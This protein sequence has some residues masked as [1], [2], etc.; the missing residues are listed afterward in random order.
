MSALLEKLVWLYSK[1][2]IRHPQLKPVTLAHWL[3]ASSK[4]TSRLAESHYNFAALEWR[5]EMNGF[6]TR[7]A[8]T[9][10]GVEG[11]YCH[12]ASLE[13][14]ITGYWRFLDRAPYTGWE[15]HTRTGE[16][17]FNFIGPT[18][19]GS[20]G[21]ADGV[22]ALMPEADQLLRDATGRPGP[23]TPPEPRPASKSGTIVL[24]PGHGGTTRVRGSS[25]NNAIS[26]S[27]VKEKKMALEISLLI[28]EQLHELGPGNDFNLGVHLTRTE[29][30]NVGIQD[31]AQLAAEK[32]ADLFFCLHFNGNDPRATRKTRGTETFFRAAENGN[33]NP[34]ADEAF[35]RR[36]HD[37]MFAAI[38]RHDSRAVDRHV[39]PDTLSGPKSLGVLR[40][41]LL[42]NVG[43]RKSCLAC[44][45]EMEFIDV[46]AVDEL[47]NTGPNAVRVRRDIARAIAEAMIEQ[48]KIMKG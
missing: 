10:G 43:G 22:L 25:P 13:S 44:Y 11:F 20:A 45:A 24:D 48:L 36:V 33:P 30:V 34:A 35:A 28:A 8:V 4:G 21:Y 1:E 40:D 29:D 27:G 26:F 46:K 12:F 39:K 5:P 2:P 47:L 41:D 37:S 16:D 31:R 19:G 32:R 9:V 7:S 14:F 6:A 42:G 17:F 18:I 23:V 15:E 3:L 38:R